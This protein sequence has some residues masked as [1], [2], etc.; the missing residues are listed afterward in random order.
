MPTFDPN[1]IPVKGPYLTLLS[2]SADS[3]L[4][5]LSAHPIYCSTSIC[6]SNLQPMP[7]Y[8]CLMKL[9]GLELD[10]KQSPVKMHKRFQQLHPAFT[11]IYKDVFA[12]R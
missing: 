4:A 7:T 10:V 1:Y 6:N 11:K 12:S 8:R 9:T 3:D 5:L 2:L